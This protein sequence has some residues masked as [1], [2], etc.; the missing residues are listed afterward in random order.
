MRQA[1]YPLSSNDLTHEEWLDLAE[2]NDAVPS[3]EAAWLQAICKILVK[4]MTGN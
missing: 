4:L 3:T 2:V 1:G